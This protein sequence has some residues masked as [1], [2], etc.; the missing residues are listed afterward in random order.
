MKPIIEV[1]NLSKQYKIGQKQRYLSLRDSVTDFFKGKNQTTKPSDFWALNDVNFEVQ[2]G[3]SIGIIGRNGAG[4]ST[5]LKILSRITPPTKGRVILRGRCAS[6]LEVGTGFHSELTG[7]ENVFMNGSILGLRRTEIAEKFDE[8]VA[9][10]GV[11]QFIDTPLKHYS[12]GMQLRLAFAV[13]AH[14]EPEILIIDEVLAVGDAEFQKKCIEKMNAVSDSGRTVIF[15]SHNMG[16]IKN[17]CSKGILLE[18]GQ[19]KSI[20]SIQDIISDYLSQYS[21]SS[22]SIIELKPTNSSATFTKI[23]LLNEKK[24]FTNSF[25]FNE[26]ITLSIEF[27]LFDNIN[28]LELSIA[29][30]SVEG[31]R[32]FYDS[33]LY[34]LQNNNR[35]YRKGKHVVFVNLPPN[36]F[37]PNF[38]SFNIALN[39]PNIVLFDYRKNIISFAIEETGKRIESYKGSQMGLINVILDWSFP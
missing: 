38:Y 19:I 28:N 7:R 8:I 35:I 24:T 5:L 30:M 4:K 25:G 21:D 23:S 18:S 36:L 2:A 6:L 33:S 31:V 34:A 14:L 15:V 3:E 10:S 26:A 13:A 22:A 11:E 9:F 39:I 17:L 27:E 37:M 29:L 16:I 32:I 20:G 12:S 1:Q